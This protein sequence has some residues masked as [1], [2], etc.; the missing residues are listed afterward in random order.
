MNFHDSGSSKLRHHP[1]GGGSKRVQRSQNHA[2]L[3]RLIQSNDQPQSPPWRSAWR[4]T[5]RPFCWANEETSACQESGQEEQEHTRSAFARS[6]RRHAKRL[7]AR[8]DQ[9]HELP[10]RQAVMK[11]F[12][13]LRRD[14]ERRLKGIGRCLFSQSP[15]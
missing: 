14:F 12:E 3:F 15:G 4:P 8:H 5:G 10:E 2:T 11:E 6:T 13:D 9:S 1:S 7:Q